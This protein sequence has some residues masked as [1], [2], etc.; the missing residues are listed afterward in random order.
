MSEKS[1]SEFSEWVESVKAKIPIN[2]LYTK[3]TGME[4]ERHDSRL[5]AKISWREDNSPSLTFAPDKNLLTDFTERVEGSDKAGKSYNVL[6]ILQK[7]GGAVN[8]AHAL[9]MACEITGEE[10]PDKYKKKSNKELGHL[11][12]NIGPKLKEVWEACQA[13]ISY[14]IDNPNKRP[15]SIVKFF[16]DRNIPFEAEFLKTMNLGIAPK[17][18]MT[19]G[20]L[21]GHGILKKGKDDKELNIYREELGDNALVY[22]LYNI[23]GA[24]CG[25]RFR[26]LSKKDFAE[27]IPIGHTCFF[28]GQRFRYRPRGRRIMIVEGEMNLVAYG[29]AVYKHLKKTSNPELVSKLDESLTIMYATGSKTNSTIIFKDQ[30]SK[31]LYLQDHDISALDEDISPKDHPILKTCA[32]IAKEISADDLVIADWEKLP[33]V[34]D[35][36]DLEN[37]LIHNE[38]KLESI[39]A[40]DTMSLSRYG[41]NAIKKYCSIIKNED[42]RREMQVKYVLAVSEMLQYSQR[43]VFKELVKKEFAIS[44]DVEANIVSQHTEVHCGPYSIDQLGR[45]VEITVDDQGNKKTKVATNFYMR[46]ND[47]TTYFSHTNNTMEKFYN[48][49]V[50]V[51]G[52]SVGMNEVESVDIIDNKTMQGFLATTASLTDL[53]F[54]NN[55]LRGKDF[56]IITSLMSS[57]PVNNKR[58]IFASLGRP[59]EDFCLTYLKTE[60]FCLFP[61]VSVIN[62]VVKYNDTFQVNLSGRNSVV[63]TLPFEFDILSESDYRKALDL[64]WYDLRHVHDCN[65]ID[66]LLGLLYDSCTR[67]LQGFGVIQNDHGFV[68]YLAGQ[69]GAFKTTAA[70]MAMSL[71]GRFK[72]QNDLLSWN[73]TG[74]SIEH[75]L[76]K[77][78]T[79]THCVDDLKIEEMASKEFIAFIHAIYGG[80]TKT[81]MDSSATKI[82]G[83]NKLKCSVIITSESENENVPESIASRLLTL[84]VRRCSKEIAL[85]REVH[86]RK[87]L[88]FYDTDVLNIDLMRGV[89]PRMIAWAQKRGV[90][91]YAESLLKWK[92]VFEKILT[93]QKNNSERPSDMVTRLVAGFEQ[94]CEFIKFEGVAPALEVDAAFEHMVEFW[95]KQIKNQMVRIEKQ[96]STYKIIDLLC[97]LINSEAIG[98]RKFKDKWI[99]SSKNYPSYPVCDITYPEGKGRKLLIV[100]QTQ[101]IKYMNSQTENSH[102]IISGKFT[103]DLKETGII[104]MINDKE[105]RYCIPDEHGNFDWKK[106]SNAVV[107][108]YNKLMETY[109]RIKND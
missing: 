86:Y 93:N 87:M 23:D 57:I 85:E 65:F 51:N 90:A 38:Y 76:M 71:L 41:I 69:S 84:R 25:L 105:A 81:R 100:S 40:I 46:I 96:S 15:V 109:T 73:G 62:G 91:P 82:R 12:H 8:F 63:E 30:L 70:V 64:F 83:G 11:P 35:K 9:Q 54:Q 67:E 55:L 101:L 20:I 28:N 95:K 29:I 106:T 1:T 37:F 10:W 5:R 48:V 104:E 6:D 36:F 16:E 68:V 17:Y 98:I 75:Q 72:S 52:K 18:D 102:P 34:K 61:K 42:N 43:E 14:M 59:F 89:T 22:P 60:T 26:Q 33:Y 24:L 7:C 88:E 94:V 3:L 49:E 2:E 53:N 107:I 21:K 79:L 99:P 97:Q 66:S 103:E 77:V 108:D 32:K 27:W 50:I 31:V 47:E 74:L 4:F 92:R 13:N 58:Y 19:Y 39:Q 45:I 80:N 78:G 44:S 56:Y